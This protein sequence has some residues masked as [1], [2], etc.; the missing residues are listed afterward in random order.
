MALWR[1]RACVCEAIRGPLLGRHGGAL[2]MRLGCDG[3]GRFDIDVGSLVHRDAHGH[4]DVKLD[5]LLCSCM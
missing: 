4:L 2:L 1:D 5:M 3:L